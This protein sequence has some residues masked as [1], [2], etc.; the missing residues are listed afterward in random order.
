[1][2]SAA[3]EVRR[4]RL[5]R[6]EI[7]IL[8]VRG[9][10]SSNQNRAETNGLNDFIGRRERERERATPD[11]NTPPHR[12]RYGRPTVAKFQGLNNISVFNL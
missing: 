7:I 10:P 11:S 9:A 1:M 6:K 8:E 5:S 3:L 2:R 4:T 12:A